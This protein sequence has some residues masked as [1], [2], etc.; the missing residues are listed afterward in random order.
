[1]KHNRKE[2]LIILTVITVALTGCNSTARPV[3]DQ[4]SDSSTTPA[5]EDQNT[6]IEAFY[7]SWNGNIEKFD[8]S[9][10]N[11]TGILAD[12][13]SLARIAPR[14]GD[15]F[16]FTSSEMKETDNPYILES[17]RALSIKDTP[18]QSGCPG[19]WIRIVRN[20]TVRAES[21]TAI[22]GGKD[23]LIYTQNKSAF[24]AVQSEDLTLWTVWELPQY[25]IWLDKET[26]IFMRMAAG[27]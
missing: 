14:G 10:K 22:S 20:G 13:T 16:N 1:M 3:S 7:V 27:L 18:I 2:L 26:G 8:H 25:G 5:G 24:L 12:I 4:E 15:R 17:S 6:G 21:A 19:S 9:H 23:I 11:M